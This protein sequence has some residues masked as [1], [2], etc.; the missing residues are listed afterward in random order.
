VGFIGGNF[1]Y[2]FLK[3]YYPGGTGVPMPSDDIW[4]EKESSKLESF[5]GSHIYEELRHKTV[6]DFGCG[7]GWTCVEMALNG[8]ERVIGVDIVEQN[9]ENARA[10]AAK[11]GV[12]DRCL[13]ARSVDEPADVVI[14]LD[15]F[16]H[17]ADPSAI[18]AAMRELL[19]DDGMAMISFGYTWYH[20]LGGH[21][22]SVFPWAHLIFTEDAF[23]RWRSEFKDDG[24]TRFGEVRGGLNQ[25]TV[26]R[27]ERIISQSPFEVAS[28]NFRPIRA[29]RWLYG[30][31]TRE[32]FTSTMQFKLVPRN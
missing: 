6:V 9:L 25:M 13:F 12:S 27:F 7:T 23:M 2:R 14:S 28:R 30:S 29:V 31:L 22:F 21:L 15:A 18:L 24:A 1:A 26:A 11:H 4:L 5:F 32:L 16:E 8:V 20:P 19:K 3:K 17:F 10:L